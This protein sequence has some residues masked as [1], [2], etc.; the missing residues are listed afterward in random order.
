MYFFFFVLKVLSCDESVIEEWCRWWWEAQGRRRDKEEEEGVR[1]PEE[2]WRICCVT[3]SLQTLTGKTLLLSSVLKH[4]LLWSESNAFPHLSPR[5]YRAV[6]ATC[7]RW[8]F[9]QKL[10][11]SVT[12][13]S[14]WWVF[15]Y[16][17]SCYWSLCRYVSS[18]K[19]FSVVFAGSP[20]LAASTRPGHQ[21][22]LWSRKTCW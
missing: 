18:Y 17:I 11:L 20:I 4:C 6:K 10:S 5:R 7:L 21:S 8:S 3:H 15:F 2:V 19:T 13:L 12:N 1:T 22:A 16:L 14:V 9:S